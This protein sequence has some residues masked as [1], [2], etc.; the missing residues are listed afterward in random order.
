MAFIYKITSPTNR[1]YIGSTTNIK[2]R[3]S[4]YKNLNCKTQ[5]RLYRSFIKYGIGNHLF[6]IIKECNNN[7]ML[8]YEAELGA[9]YDVLGANGLNNA[10]PK[11]F[12]YKAIS[13]ETRMLLSS[14]M[15]NRIFTKEWKEKISKKARLR[16]GKL[17]PA[18]GNKRPDFVL[19]SKTRDRTGANN[20]MF[21]KN[22]SQKTKDILSLKHS[23]PNI[24]KQKT[25]INIESGVFHNSVKEAA[26]CYN[27][28]YSTL[29]SYLNNS[30]RKN[31]TNL[32][33][34]N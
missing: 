10:L 33:Y 31:K 2:K 17:N 28:K 9:L 23:K 24:K 11:T 14:K 26:F 30:I 5:P 7:D 27:Y 22:H 20:S 3:F 34:A 15:K 12:E 4:Y 29:V 8:K 18:Y 16:V 25:V 21:G 32:I 1:I 19:M 6:E 13:E